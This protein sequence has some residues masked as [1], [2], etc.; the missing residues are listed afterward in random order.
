MNNY[1]FDPMEWA[2]KD[3]KHNETP[4]QALPAVRTT[5]AVADPHRI[6]Q[7]VDELVAAGINLTETYE[8]W[9][10]VGSALADGLGEAGRTAFHRLSELSAKYNPAECDRKYDDCLRNPRRTITAGTLFYLARQAGLVLHD[11][12]TPPPPYSPHAQFAQ[13]AQPF[14]DTAPFPPYEENILNMNELGNSEG[15]QGTLSVAAQTAQTAH[16]A[17][18]PAAAYTFSDRLDEAVWTRFFHPVLHAA[19]TPTDRDKLLLGLLTLI[20]GT[21]PNLYGYYG[22]MEVYPPLFLFVIGQAATRKG[23]LNACRAVLNPL[24]QAI[25]GTYAR[26]RSEYEQQHAEW[27]AAAGHR[28]TLSTRGTEPQPPTYRTLYLPANSTSSALVRQ[29]ADNGGQGILFST[30]GGDELATAFRQDYSNYSTQLRAIFHHEP[31]EL[32]RAT[33]HL[34][35]RVEKPRMAVLLTSTPGQLQTL[36]PSMENG[37]PTRF[38]FYRLMEQ[39]AWQSPFLRHDRTLEKELAPCGEAYYRLHRTMEALE[40]PVQFVLTRSQEEQFN[41]F[42]SALLAEQHEL[43]GEEITPFVFRLGLSAFRIAMVLSLLRLADEREGTGPLFLPAEQ[44]LTCDDRDI[45]IALTLTDCLMGHT[46]AVF[47]QLKG[48]TPQP[49]AT[50]AEGLKGTKLRFF[51][52]LPPSFSTAEARETA[53]TQGIHW[54]SARRYLLE[55]TNRQKLLVRVSQ[56]NYRKTTQLKPL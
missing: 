28:S 1:T 41:A 21:V 18:A 8:A 23:E 16:P 19:T 13:T 2:N 3:A 36:F 43:L 42:F 40:H 5:A 25:R 48:R 34:H 15:N 39:T 9:F 26:A 44:A 51:E 27:E 53:R 10:A 54:D 38:L 17:Q 37:L 29:L 46:M 50:P 7:L 45:R 22:G 6:A 56:G 55:L 12:P 11:V 14:P 52:T 49:P 4:T 20:S 30:E 31:V 33:D 47:D 32:Q 24:D 35:I